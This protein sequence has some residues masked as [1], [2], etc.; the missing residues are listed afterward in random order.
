MSK[1]FLKVFLETALELF[2]S[3]IPSWVYS[4]L[5]EFLDGVLART[6]TLPAMVG[7]APDFLKGWVRNF[8]LAQI[9]D[10]VGSAILK[11][12]L[13]R[14]VTA[15]DGAILDVIWDL[16]MDKLNGTSTARPMLAMPNGDEFGLAAIVDSFA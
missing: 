2:K 13:N 3:K 4:F 15:M 9:A 14:L 10:H 11:A 6:E 1:E 7:A 8:L 5:K 12:I 16:T